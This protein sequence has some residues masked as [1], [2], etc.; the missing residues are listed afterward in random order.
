L[1]HATTPLSQPP[2]DPLQVLSALQ[3]LVNALG[4]D[5]PAA[6]PLLL[7][8]L[9]HALSPV[10]SR[11]PELL[12]DGL[13]L[14]LVV[15]RNAPAPASE[16]LALFPLLIGVMANSTGEGGMWATWLQQCSVEQSAN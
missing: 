9:Q 13:V 1:C 16:L 2:A 5:S 11:E 8:L 6:Y 7:P 3:H 4:S 10:S 12:E 14:W 15:L